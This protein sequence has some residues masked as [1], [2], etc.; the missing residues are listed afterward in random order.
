MFSAHSV[1]NVTLGGAEVSDYMI[2]REIY[3]IRLNKFVAGAIS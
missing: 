1:Y 2:C 3:K